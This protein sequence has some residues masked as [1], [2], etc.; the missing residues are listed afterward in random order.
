MHGRR[1]VERVPS[2]KSVRPNSIL[3]KHLMQSCVM[4]GI[5]CGSAAPNATSA[6]SGGGSE[7]DTTVHAGT[8]GRPVS[9]SG[10]TASAEG[11]TTSIGGNSSAT[12]ASN[13]GATSSLGGTTPAGGTLGR[14]GT[15]PNG[16]TATVS[17][18]ASNSAGATSKG[19]TS[20]TGG[21][22]GTGGTLDTAGSTDAGGKTSSGGNSGASGTSISGGTSATAGAPTTG[23][24]VASGG[25]LATG[26]SAATGA[27]PSPCG[28]VTMTLGSSS[29]SEDASMQ[30]V[31]VSGT[32][33]KE[34][35]VQNNNYGDPTGS[36]QVIDVLG[37]GFTI[38]NSSARS[39]S[40]SSAAPAAFPSIYVGCN[41]DTAHGTFSTWSDTGLPKQISAIASIQ[42]PSTFGSPDRHPLRTATMTPF[43][44]PSWCA[45]TS[46]KAALRLAA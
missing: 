2:R 17:G 8:A 26:G 1:W 34:Y 44:D 31:K 9:V 36:I 40:G 10:G 6:Q 24:T 16:G 32:D 43:P 37:N 27:G 33:C 5:G 18:G 15:A 39:P 42:R 45:C 11:G 23:G 3:R 29:P 21:L 28:S 4:L 38:Q 35:V 41:G 20:A 14:G 46:Q 22:V 13:A 7:G 30:R 12:G 25:T 19:G